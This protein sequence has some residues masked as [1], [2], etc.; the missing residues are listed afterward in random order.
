MKVDDLKLQFETIL[1]SAYPPFIYVQ[2][3]SGANVAREAMDNVLD[4]CLTDELVKPAVVF[5]DCISCFS[6]RL[7]FDTILNTLI[8]HRHTEE[9]SEMV[10]ND[11]MDDFLH[12]LCGLFRASSSARQMNIVII[13]EH[14]EKLKEMNPRLIHPLSRL[15]ELVRRFFSIYE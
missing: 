3:L 1:A 14:A 11:S 6:H 2:D 4:H 7:I 10:R 8:K 13:F 15:R 9:F 12:N 5:V